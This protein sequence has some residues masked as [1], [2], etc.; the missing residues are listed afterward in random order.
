MLG[1]KNRK[2]AGME[3]WWKRIMEAQVKHLNKDLG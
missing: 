3:P 1:V 2:R